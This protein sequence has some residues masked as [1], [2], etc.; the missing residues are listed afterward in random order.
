MIRILV[1]CLLTLPFFVT[2]QKKD[3][4]FLIQPYLQDASPNSIKVLWE[5]S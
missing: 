1:L 3:V 5:I 2:A 4:T